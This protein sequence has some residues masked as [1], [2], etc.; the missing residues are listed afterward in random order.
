MS[1]HSGEVPIGAANLQGVPGWEQI[2]VCS[3]GGHWGLQLQH[4]EVIKELVELVASLADLLAI[5][6]AVHLLADFVLQ[7]VHLGA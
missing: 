5:E 4:F 7:G 1:L 3:K 6:L 2:G